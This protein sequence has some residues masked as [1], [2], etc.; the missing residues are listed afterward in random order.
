MS[1]LDDTKRREE[2]GK[3]ITIVFLVVVGIAFAIF[4]L[5]RS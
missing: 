5:T 4:W 1:E 3:K 2:Q